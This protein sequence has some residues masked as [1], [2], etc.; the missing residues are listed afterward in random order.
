MSGLQDPNPM[1]GDSGWNNDLKGTLESDP[2]KLETRYHCNSGFLPA[3]VWE[4]KWKS[5]SLSTAL[6]GSGDW[7]CFCSQGKQSLLAQYISFCFF[8]EVGVK[9]FKTFKRLERNSSQKKSSDRRCRVRSRKRKAT[10][11][12]QSPE[13]RFGRRD[14]PRLGGY[15]LKKQNPGA[16][17]S[18]CSPLKS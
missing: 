9:T 2:N 18:C 7:G 11:K 4:W 16:I 15:F 17:L 14:I 3:K 5:P 10:R 12:L 8:E 13:K 1:K 6:L